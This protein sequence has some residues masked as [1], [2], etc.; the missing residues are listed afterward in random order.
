VRSGI[1]ETGLAFHRVLVLSGRRAG[2]ESPELGTEQLWRCGLG[3][4]DAPAPSAVHRSGKVC[5]RATLC[6]QSRRRCGREYGFV[7]QWRAG[8]VTRAGNGPSYCVTVS[9]RRSLQ[10]NRHRTA[11]EAVLRRLL[12]ADGDAARPA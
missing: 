12:Q 4:G 10:T 5:V 6:D 2:H 11:G 7:Q 3:H 8:K 9:D 1:W